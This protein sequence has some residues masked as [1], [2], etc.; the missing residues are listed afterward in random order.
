MKSRNGFVSNSSTT[1]FIFKLDQYNLEQIKL[2]LKDL[3]GFY[4]RFT[5]NNLNYDDVFNGPRIINE[6]EQNSLRYYDI[7]N[8]IG[9]VI[10]TSADDN[11]IPSVLFDLI[12]ERY[13]AEYHHLG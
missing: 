9:N 1:S 7:F 6:K 11:S 3:L 13:D 5:N 10:I 12:M 4:N 8:V 2:D